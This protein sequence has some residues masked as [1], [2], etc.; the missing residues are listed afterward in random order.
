MKQRLLEYLVCPTSGKK[1]ELEIGEQDG[2]E[3]LEGVLRSPLGQQYLIR[4]GIPRFV[5]SEA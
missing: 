2:D 5:P 1:L 3:I 4:G